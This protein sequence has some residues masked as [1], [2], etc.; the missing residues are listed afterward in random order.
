VTPWR[1]WANRVHDGSL[2]GRDDSLRAAAPFA[3]AR[4]SRAGIWIAKPLASAG[5][6]ATALAAGASETFYGRLVLVALVLGW[7]GD[8]LLIP[9]SRAVFAA[10]IASFLLGHL[11]FAAAFASRG[12]SLGWTA[13]AALALVA[14][15]VAAWRWL[16]P[17]VPASLSSAVTLYMIVISAMLACAIGTTAHASAP[18]VLVGAAM[19]FASDLSV[20]RNRFVAPGFANKLWGLPLYYGGQL[21]LAASVVRSAISAA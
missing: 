7:L 4:G 3:E 2:R 15:V 9:R 14:P 13:V 19:F 8:V 20:A 12:L 18:L 10:G 17:H 5:F 6:I 1:A 11:V 21:L 16:R